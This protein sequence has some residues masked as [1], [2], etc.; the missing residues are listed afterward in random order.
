MAG[1][2]V[3]ERLTDEQRDEIV[4]RY[5]ESRAD[6]DAE[7]LTQAVLAQEYGVSRRTIGN[8]LIDSGVLER[9]LRRTRSDVMVAQA[10]AEAAA[11]RVMRETVKSAF[12]MR[13]EKYEYITQGDRRDILDRAG[14]RATK[15]EKQEVNITFNGG[16][17]PIGVPNRAGE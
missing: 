8:V 12:K 11:A 13:N 5:I 7:P 14:V 3:E 15:E 2:K 10:I 6:P 17:V 4:R 1:K 16:G 9:A